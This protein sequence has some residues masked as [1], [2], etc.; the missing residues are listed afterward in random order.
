MACGTRFSRNL[1]VDRSSAGGRLHRN[2]RW[3]SGLLLAFIGAACAAQG[4]VTYGP[5]AYA[6]AL[7][8]VTGANAPSESSSVSR[9]LNK[10]QVCKGIYGE[11]NKNRVRGHQFSGEEKR[12]IR[13]G[14]NCNS[15]TTGN[16]G[17]FVLSVLIVLYLFV[18]VAIVCDELFVS[19]LEV[20]AEK[21]ELSDDVSGATLM[22]A[23]GSAP[24]LATAFLGTFQGSTVGLGTIVG[25]AVFNVLFVIGMCAIATPKEFVPL[26]LTW[27]PLARDC[28]YYILTLLAL[29]IWFIGG[30]KGSMLPIYGSD[31]SSGA[32]EGWEAGVQFALYFGYVF[33]M[34][35]NVRL[36][37]WVKSRLNRGKVFP[38][39]SPAYISWGAE[40]NRVTKWGSNA[41]TT[42]MAPP[43]MVRTAWRL[44][45]ALSL[46]LSQ[47][48]LPRG[49]FSSSRA[50]PSF[51]HVT[52]VWDVWRK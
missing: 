47:T 10:K 14:A 13:T 16:P 17:I 31:Y 41:T 7:A 23:G 38:T 1:C 24:E 21:W 4:A 30:G 20:I 6:H 48:R 12:K 27:W 3:Q 46:S 35:N 22:A 15:I 36:E 19:A 51:L 18:G 2:A 34:K 50:P 33:L 52:R 37:K 25:S 39:Q 29:L 5:G 49:V 43:K 32:I 44:K 42:Q 26:Q 9:R 40:K 28:T 45:R 11:G 8:L